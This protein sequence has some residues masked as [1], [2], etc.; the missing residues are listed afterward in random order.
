MIDHPCGDGRRSHFANDWRIGPLLWMTLMAASV[1]VSV[2][3]AYC[4]EKNPMPSGEA[5][6]L[7]QLLA[8]GLQESGFVRS[9]LSWYRYEIDSILVINVQPGSICARAL[10]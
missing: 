2:T 3:V 10:H 9:G 5:S 8:P 6:K 4:S 1:W 7:A